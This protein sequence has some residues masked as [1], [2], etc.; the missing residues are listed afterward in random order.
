MR[1]CSFSAAGLWTKELRVG[2]AAGVADIEGPAVWKRVKS[3]PH[4]ASRNEA[5][6]K[7]GAAR[8]RLISALRCPTPSTTP[9]TLKKSDE[10]WL[11]DQL[12]L[13]RLKHFNP[14]PG[15]RFYKT[16]DADTFIFQQLRYKAGCRQIG[17]RPPWNSHSKVACPVPSKIQIGDCPY[18]SNGQNLALDQCVTPDPGQNTARTFGVFY[19]RGVGPDAY[20]SLTRGGLGGQ[21]AGRALP[22]ADIR[23]N[24]RLALRQELLLHQRFVRQ[25]PRIGG[26]AA[27]AVG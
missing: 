21:E 22:V 11:A 16:S 19:G 7:M 10:L 2:L 18:L 14:R 8:S 12:N 24:Q 6:K 4:P 26:L 15:T 25:S 20:F 23:R 5:P 27:I 1:A 9:A 3:P 13:P 17:K